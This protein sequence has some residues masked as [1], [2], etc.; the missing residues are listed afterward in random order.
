MCQTSECVCVLTAAT[1]SSVKEQQA[2]NVAKE[3]F[4]I[5]SA[6]SF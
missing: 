6:K 3:E 4:E 2:L 5:L 1:L